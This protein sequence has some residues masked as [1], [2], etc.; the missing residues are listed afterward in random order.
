MIR[1]VGVILFV[2]LSA[3]AIAASLHAWRT[4]QTYGSFRFLGFEFM[5]VLVGWNAG[6]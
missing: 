6:R 5:A 4:Q 3:V 1:P 2:L